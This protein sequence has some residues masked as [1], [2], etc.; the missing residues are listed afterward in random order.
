[1]RVSVRVGSPGRDRLTLL[2]G[3][4][5]GG[6]SR[7]P[8]APGRQVAPLNGIPGSAAGLQVIGM[9][10]TWDTPL[11]HHMAGIT[12]T[13]ARAKYNEALRQ[14]D[15]E[16]FFGLTFW[17]PNI[18]I[19]RDPRCCAAVSG[20]LLSLSLASSDPSRGHVRGFLCIITA[21]CTY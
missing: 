21:S 3:G 11:V 12:S 19:F 17:A 15:H 5:P 2:Q 7:A 20:R 14:D 13:E 18:N 6:Q 8:A 1:M 9:A 10:A 16:R 4:P